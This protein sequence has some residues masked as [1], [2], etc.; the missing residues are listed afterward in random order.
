M[1]ISSYA[2]LQPASVTGAV[3]SVAATAPTVSN[4]AAGTSLVLRGK[5]T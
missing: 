1:S 5:D 2:L 3:S 4:S